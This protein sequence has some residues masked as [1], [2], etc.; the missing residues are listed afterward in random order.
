MLSKTTSAF[1][2]LQPKVYTKEN[3]M[4]GA[5]GTAE[6]EVINNNLVGP[7]PMLNI[8]EYSPDIVSTE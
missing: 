3:I 1:E 4:S 6:P 2:S 5:K 7:N 8:R